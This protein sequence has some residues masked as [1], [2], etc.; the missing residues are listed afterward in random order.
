MFIPDPNISIPDPES[1]MK[2][3]PDP[4]Q[5]KKGFLT[6]TKFVSELSEI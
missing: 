5:R 2:K 3:I 4:H 6:Q 1:R